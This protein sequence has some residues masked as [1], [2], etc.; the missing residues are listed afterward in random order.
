MHA[1]RI[2][3]MILI[4]KYMLKRPRLNQRHNMTKGHIPTCDNTLFCHLGVKWGEGMESC[5]FPCGDQGQSFAKTVF[6]HHKIIP[7][8]GHSQDLVHPTLH[9]KT[10]V[11]L[12]QQLFFH[13][14]LYLLVNQNYSEALKWHTTTKKVFILLKLF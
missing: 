9:F 13:D 11:S 4:T 8:Y 2:R 14:T 3:I 1:M 6:V 10:L 12:T 7:F 5:E